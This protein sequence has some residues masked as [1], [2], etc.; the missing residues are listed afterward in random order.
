MGYV[1]ENSGLLNLLHLH[2]VI[3]LLC[4]FKV[5]IST[6]YTYRE[7]IGRMPHLWIHCK[8]QHQQDRKMKVYVMLDFCKEHC[9]LKLRLGF[10]VIEAI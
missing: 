1:I 10:S 9:S 8:W 5:E 6:L 7:A 3:V 2:K 4:I